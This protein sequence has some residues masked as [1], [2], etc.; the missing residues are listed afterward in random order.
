MIQQSDLHELVSFLNTKMPHKHIKY[1]WH[2]F[3]WKVRRTNG[4]NV[5]IGHIMRKGRLS[6]GIFLSKNYS[7]T[8]VLL[9]VRTLMKHYQKLSKKAPYEIIKKSLRGWATRLVD[10]PKKLLWVH[11]WGDWNRRLQKGYG[12]LSPKH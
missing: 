6:L 1:L 8:L 5:Y 9:I 11:L 2:P 12:C 10:G 3:I 7:L 4:G